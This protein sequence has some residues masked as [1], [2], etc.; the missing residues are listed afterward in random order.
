[1][2]DLSISFLSIWNT[3]MTFNILMYEFYYICRFWIS[4]SWLISILIMGHLFLFPCIPLN[5]LLALILLVPGYFLYSYKC[6]WALFWGAVKVFGNS[7]FQG[8]VF[9]ALLGRARTT[10]SQRLVLPRYWGKTW[11]P[12]L[13]LPLLW[14]FPLRLVEAGTVLS[15]M[16]PWL[17]PFPPSGSLLAHLCCDSRGPVQPAPL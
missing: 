12:F 2:L 16:V 13:K 10:F 15:A 4:F 7:L 9:K 11:V 1:M 3:I 5:F 17:V 8:L 14:G 6:S